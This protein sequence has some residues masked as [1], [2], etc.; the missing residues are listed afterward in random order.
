VRGKALR[1]QISSKTSKQLE[2]ERDM[3]IKSKKSRKES[4]KRVALKSPG[5]EEITG[6]QEL[7]SA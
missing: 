2:K 3:S 5:I 1:K 4:L 6:S 7:R